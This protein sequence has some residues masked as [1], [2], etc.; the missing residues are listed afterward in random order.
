MPILLAGVLGGMAWAGIV[1]FLRD[2]ANASEILVS[3]MLVYVADQLLNYLVYGAVEGSG[4]LQL[5]ADDH[6]PRRRPRSRGC[7][8]ACA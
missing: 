1:A 5:P 4:R 2:R 3:L 6:L 8:R 7:S